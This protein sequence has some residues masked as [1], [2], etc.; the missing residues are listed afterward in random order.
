[1]TFYDLMISRRSIRQFQQK[2]VP[3]ELLEKMVNSARL[4]PS[5]ANH[6]PLEFVVVDEKNS[7]DLIFP[8]L[9]WA[10]Y[11]KPEGNPK[12]GQEPMAYVVTLVN[13]QVKVKNCEWDAGAAV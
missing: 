6:Q 8:C 7:R 10:E 2:P 9:K 11:I 1:M 3:R 5:A 13:T 4:A 12:P